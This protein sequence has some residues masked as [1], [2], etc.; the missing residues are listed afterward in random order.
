MITDDGPPDYDVP[1]PPEVFAKR[2]AELRARM[3]EEGAEPSRE[4]ARWFLRRYPTLVERCRYVTRKQ[5]ELARAPKVRA[6][7][8]R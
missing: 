7:P 8:A 1:L 4:L 3:T 2:L 5:R 6:S